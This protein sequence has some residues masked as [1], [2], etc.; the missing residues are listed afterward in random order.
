MGANDVIFHTVP[1]S[2]KSAGTLSL[3]VDVIAAKLVLAASSMLVVT[4]D[5]TSYTVVVFKLISVVVVCVAVGVGV[6]GVVVVEVEVV[7]SNNVVMYCDVMT[8][9]FAVTLA[10]DIMLSVLFVLLYSVSSDQ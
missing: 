8:L 4:V 5:M 10:V 1:L 3:T 7:F 9:L 2:T 6:G